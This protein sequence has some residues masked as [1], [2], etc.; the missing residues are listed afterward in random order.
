MVERI[1]KLCKEQGTTI[2]ALQKRLGFG[3]GTIRRWDENRPGI[4]RVKLVAEAL[5]VSPEY[6]LTGTEKSPETITAPGL[7]DEVMELARLIDA[8]PDDQRRLLLVQ[9]QAL[10]QEQKG[11]GS[12]PTVSKSQ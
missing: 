8:L 1:K 5:H 12:S 6:L 10:A 9:V 7:S 11:R 2:T 4:D 3:N